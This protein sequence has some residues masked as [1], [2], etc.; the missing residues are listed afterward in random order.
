MYKKKKNNTVFIVLGVIF[1]CLLFSSLF[2]IK[3][4]NFPNVFLKDGVMFVNNVVKSPFKFIENNDL[5]DENEKLKLEIENLKN[6]EYE[7]IELNNQISD[8]KNMLSINNLLVS[9]EY[10]NA[11]VINRNLG[12]WSEKLTIDKGES[13]GITN[14]MAV[15][16]N[17]TM[18]GITKNVS[19]TSSDVLL[20]SN[21]KFPMN[22][23]VKIDI[24]DK[25]IYGVLNKFGDNLYDVIGVVENIDI[26]VGSMV[27]TSGLGN[28]FPAG[29]FI[30]YVNEIV[31]DNFDLSKVVEVTPGTSFDD[32]NYVTV[33]KRVSE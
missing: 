27:T 16:S 15:I 7:N 14:N 28:N 13:S 18:I 32:I 26:P 21:V 25:E 23:S 29:L 3:N 30:G 17:G 8:L 2:I 20:F 22:I 12:Y 24:G 6:L 19:L 1:I 5:Q 31:T 9:K 4:F 33:V 11:S 10:I